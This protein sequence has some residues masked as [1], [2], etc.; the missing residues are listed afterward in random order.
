MSE[1]PELN[2][3]PINDLR[4]RLLARLPGR[5]ER[6]IVYGS[7]ARAE[8]GDESDVDILV[9]VDENSP[10]LVETARAARYEVMERYQYHPLL[11]LLLLTNEDWQRLAKYSAGLKQNIQ[12]EGV[13]VWSRS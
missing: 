13:I 9:V 3:P 7:Y 12:N 11:S 5:I 4:D 1:Q 6:I 10:K 2:L 8:A